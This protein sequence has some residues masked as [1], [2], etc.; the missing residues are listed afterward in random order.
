MLGTV[1]YA[2]TSLP[3]LA[4]PQVADPVF[5]GQNFCLLRALGTPRMGFAVSADGRLAAG[6]DGRQLAI[7]DRG[8]LRHRARRFSIP[9]VTNAAF[10]F[11][12]RLWVSQ[13]QDQRTVAGIWRIDPGKEPERVG[14]F[15]PVALVGHSRGVALIEGAGRLVSLG[16]EGA[17][18]GF[19]QLP[20]P[21]GSGSQLSAD[22]TGE[23]LAVV[24]QGGVL[25]YAAGDLSPSTAQAPC[26][27][28]YMWWS[29]LAGRAL[30]SC[31]PEESWALSWQPVA[32]ASELADG[33]PRVHS[34]LVPLT[35]SYVQSC[36]QLPCSAPSPL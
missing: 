4:S 15:A 19:A 31:A 1:L 10:D 21:L 16:S 27:V 5:G 12:G 35:G 34:V 32:G 33:R 18:L 23:W 11:S 28:E 6:Y 25:L 36:E 7:C 2:A 17:V 20:V 22:A 30:L 14:D 9:G 13:A 29:K 3:F 24:A 26:G 8:S